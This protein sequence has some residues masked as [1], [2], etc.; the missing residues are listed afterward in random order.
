MTEKEIHP[1]KWF[2]PENS[3]VLIIGTFPTAKRNWSYDFFYPNTANL[4]WRIMANISGDQLLHFS[5]H[6]AATERK[7]LLKKLKT[8]VT[9]M[10]MQVMRNDKS[11]LDEKLIPLEYMD[12]F[13][14][15]D[16]NPTIEK[17]IFTSSSGKVS[18]A[19]WFN[20]F[21]LSRNITHKFPN[22]KKPVKSTLNY[23]HKSV[24]LVVLYST[25]PRA[26]NRVSFE[27]LVELYKNELTT[28]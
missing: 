27:K 13:Q 26:A 14:L 7:K 15:L 4:F 28:F 12:I 21:L 24:E 9:D 20:N 18:A 3:K 16:E 5:G 22:G 19:R 2:A 17:I 23:K 1:W 25:S 10:G 8:A 6:E 11:S